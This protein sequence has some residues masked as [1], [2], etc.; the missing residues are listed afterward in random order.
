[1][2]FFFYIFVWKKEYEEQ[3]MYRYNW[4]RKQMEHY[5]HYIIDYLIAP[6]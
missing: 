2:I 3:R 1:M 6:R 5:A 4:S